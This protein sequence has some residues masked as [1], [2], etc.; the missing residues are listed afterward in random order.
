VNRI[1]SKNIHVS[2]QNYELLSQNLHSAVAVRII[3][4]VA[5]FKQ[6]NRNEQVFIF[7]SHFYFIRTRLG[8]E[9]YVC[10]FVCMYVNLLPQQLV[11]EW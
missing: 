1:I 3:S 11:C 8:T 6:G 9:L 5:H 4:P 2:A 7:C 10:L